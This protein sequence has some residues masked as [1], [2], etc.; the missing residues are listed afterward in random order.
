MTRSTDVMPYVLMYHSI[1]DVEDDPHL[2]TVS[3]RRFA[4][5]MS[6]LSKCGL[7]GVSM[8]E[9]RQA[10]EHGAARGL[11]GLTFDDGYADFATRALPILTRFGFNATVFMVAG[12]IGGHN[13]WDEG[14][15]KPL[16]SLQQ[17]RA[18]AAR[19][20]EVASHGMEHLSLPKATE[21][22]LRQ[23]LHESRATLE[24]LL[25][26]PVTGFA[27]PYGHVSDREVGEVARAGYAYGCAIWDSHPGRHALVRT[28]VGDRDRRMR[29]R[30]KLLR[31]ELR[32]KARV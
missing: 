1:D 15:R 31:H 25:D 3:P 32:W 22:Q 7:R 12:Q 8:A 23:E 10:Q 29:M 14:P 13:A 18:V 6:W 11:V 17:L 30:A 9:L 5:Q 21:S 26:R 20:I 28:Y 24:G 27:Y 2:V 19:G 4:Q 16:M